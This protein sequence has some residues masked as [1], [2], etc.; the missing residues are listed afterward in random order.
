[1]LAVGGEFEGVKILDIGREQCIQTLEGHATRSSNNNYM[2]LEKP[3]CTL[4]GMLQ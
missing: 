4:L 1:M 2:I 3:Y